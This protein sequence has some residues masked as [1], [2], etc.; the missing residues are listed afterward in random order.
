MKEKI[1]VFI[2]KIKY[3]LYHLNKNINYIHDKSSKIRF[4]ILLDIIWCRIRYRLTSN[5][6]RIYEY[7][8][9]GAEKRNTYTNIRRHK[10]ME[11]FL[12]NK[13]ITNVISDKELFMLRF[14]DYLKREVI[15]VNNLN[16]KQYEELCLKY[17]KLICRSSKNS[18]IKTYKVYNLDDYRSPAYMID[19]IKKDKLVLIEKDFKQNK[20][21]DDI[22]SDLVLI[23]VTTIFDKKPLILSS[24]IKFKEKEEIISGCINTNNGKIIGHLKDKDGKNYTYDF[25]GFEIPKYNEIIELSKVLAKEMEEIKEIE[26]SFAINNRGTVYLM[27]ANLYDDFVFAQTPEFLKNRIGFNSYY[28]SILKSYFDF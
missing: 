25:N 13:K 5:E 12:Y 16:F 4:L 9:I 22:N 23:N 26:W 15:D 14:K 20:K 2:K 17:K 1:K 11:K 27:D 6:Y 18:F 28:K 21:L 24:S 8:M 19:K 7:Y 10:S 3:N